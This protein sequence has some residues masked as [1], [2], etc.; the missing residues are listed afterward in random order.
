MEIALAKLEEWMRDYYH[1]VDH[2]IGSSGVRDLTIAEL[3]DLCGF[4]LAELDS[5]LL[6]DGEPYGSR[7]LRTVLANRW[8]GGDID[9]VMVTHGSSEAIYLTM[10]TAVE[11]GD[12]I[13]VV[14][15][16]YQQ[17]H[18]IAEA[19]GC[20]V[21]RWPLRRDDGFSVD[22]DLL[23]E[24]VAKHHPRMIVVNFPHNPTGTSITPQQQRD[25]VA[26]AQA[27]QAW[28]VWDH[29]FGEMTY[30]ADPLPLPIGWY[31]RSIVFGTFS[32]SY[33]LAGLRVGWC[34]G[35]PALLATMAELRDYIALYVSPVLEFFAVQ[36]VTHADR[37]VA[38]QHEYAREN[39]D[40][41]TKWASERQDLIRFAPPA[42]GV[43][44]FAEFPQLTD[45]TPLCHK[46]AQDHRVLLVPGSCFGDEYARYARLR[47]GGTVDELT[48]GLGHLDEL[49][50]AGT[51]L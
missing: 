43:T 14:E 50:R 3:R 48:T 6:L 31:D 10:Y 51:R 33:G 19:R 17:L 28:L 47:F 11:P 26:I 41:L 25:L 5:L 46:L 9:P 4:D 38:L 2:D 13:I 22:L 27:E 18:S 39:L 21:V 1:A 12:T 24:L 42:G 20:N 23:R 44:T 36:A 7:P 40:L 49:L 35:S 8:T 37:I 29:A 30:T 34:L 15:P 45:A 16:A 32:K